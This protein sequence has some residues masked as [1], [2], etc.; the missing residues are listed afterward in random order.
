MRTQS[1]QNKTLQSPKSTQR[2]PLRNQKNF[3][4]T[5]PGNR[6]LSDKYYLSTQKQLYHST[7]PQPSSQTRALRS[8]TKYDSKEY[9]RTST[10]VNS[11]TKFDNNLPQK[12]Y[13]SF[14]SPKQ[15]KMTLSTLENLDPGF[16]SQEVIEHGLMDCT[17]ALKQLEKVIDVVIRLV[18]MRKLGI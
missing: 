12:R 4:N 8:D 9:Y 6:T 10:G 2:S 18:L 7:N 15:T 11:S 1:P 5:S 17:R 14:I 3:G 13:D 16:P